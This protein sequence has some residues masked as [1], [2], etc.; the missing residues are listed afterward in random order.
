MT[1]LLILMK[2]TSFTD[3]KMDINIHLDVLQELSILVM[4]YAIMVHQA[5]YMVDQSQQ[6]HQHHQI[7]FKDINLF[8]L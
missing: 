1:T 2:I 6:H 5:Q 4:V 8:L 7:V 3:A